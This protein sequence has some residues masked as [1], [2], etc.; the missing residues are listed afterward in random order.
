MRGIEWFNDRRI[1]R[2]ANNQAMPNEKKVAWQGKK[3]STK[4]VIFE[5]FNKKEKH[6]ICFRSLAFRSSFFNVSG[7]WYLVLKPT[8]SFTNP[9]GYRES[10]FESAYMSGLKRL[11]NN[12]AVFNYFRFFGYY[13]SYVDLFTLNYPYL[14]INPHFSL[15]LI[16]RLEEKTWNPVKV[17]ERPIDAPE[18]DLKDD[19]EILDNTLFD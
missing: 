5:M 17:L 8:W 16:P 9:G 2:F 12:N 15:N 14:K 18:V 3:K 4:T 7:D 13:L 1:F 19:S 6:I 10:R 11:E